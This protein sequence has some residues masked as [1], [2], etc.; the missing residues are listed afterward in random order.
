MLSTEELLLQSLMTEADTFNP[1]FSCLVF[2]D[3]FS[4][5]RS[6]MLY[7]VTLSVWNSVCALASVVSP[8]YCPQL[9]LHES[10]ELLTGTGTLPQNTSPLMQQ[11]QLVCGF[12]LI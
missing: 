8:L 6:Q 7:V 3:F 4:N 1:A 2:P 10:F 11:K 12:S 9:Y 5:V